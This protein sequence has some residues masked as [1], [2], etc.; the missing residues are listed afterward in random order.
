MTMP[1]TI[2]MIAASTIPPVSM[3]DWRLSLAHSRLWL[4]VSTNWSCLRAFLVCWSIL[5]DLPFGSPRCS[6]WRELVFAC[7]RRRALSLSGQGQK[8]RQ[9]LFL[10]VAPVLAY[11]YFGDDGD[12]EFGYVFHL[13]FDQCLEFF[14]FFGDYVEEEF[15]VNLEGHLG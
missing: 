3:T 15:V 9:H 4:V 2:T 13:L 6:A 8:R 10:D 12:R 11:A 14:G 5:S 1:T 7:A